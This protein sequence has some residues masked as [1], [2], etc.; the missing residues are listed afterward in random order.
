M[1]LW[2]TEEHV[3]KPGEDVELPG[4]VHEGGK[5]RSYGRRRERKDGSETWK[6][7]FRPG[8]EEWTLQDGIEKQE[9]LMLAENAEKKRGRKAKKA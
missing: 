5:T 6:L 8:Q 4:D 9:E 3:E 1:K 2:C 7:Y